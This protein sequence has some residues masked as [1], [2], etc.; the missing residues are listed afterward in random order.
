[1]SRKQHERFELVPRVDSDSGAAVL[2]PGP[3]VSACISFR[4]DRHRGS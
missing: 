4:E 2:P 1:M 3:W